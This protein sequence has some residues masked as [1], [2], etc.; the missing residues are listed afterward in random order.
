M[1]FHDDV[2]A[3]FEEDLQQER[4]NPLEHYV[5]RRLEEG[6][7]GATLFGIAQVLKLQEQKDSIFLGTDSFE[8]TVKREWVTKRKNENWTG[9]DF[10]GFCEQDGKGALRTPT[11]MIS[12]SSANQEVPQE[13]KASQVEVTT[14]IMETQTPLPEIAIATTETDPVE[15]KNCLVQACQDTNVAGVQTDLEPDRNP[16]FMMGSHWDLT[17]LTAESQPA[18]EA[19]LFRPTEFSKDEKNK[20]KRSVSG[21]RR[22]RKEKDARPEETPPPPPP[23]PKSI[24]QA[25]VEIS[26]ETGKEQ[27]KTPRAAEGQKDLATTPRVDSLNTME[28]P[29]EVPMSYTPDGQSDARE[30]DLEINRVE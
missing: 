15:M 22:N 4:S 17:K 28:E 29:A 27:D 1:A 26:S 7:D 5:R 25:L 2:D 24:T 8:N 12:I 6:I 11:G 10:T 21:A 13:N 30:R 9:K 19:F 18:K 20:R 3:L 23:K 14:R 16:L